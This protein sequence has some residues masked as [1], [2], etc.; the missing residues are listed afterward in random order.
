MRSSTRVT[1]QSKFLELRYGDL[2][3]LRDSRQ[4]RF[5]RLFRR[6]GN[7]FEEVTSVRIAGAS[8]RAIWV[9]NELR[10]NMQISD[11]SEEVRHGSEFLVRRDLF[12]VCL[13]QTLVIVLIL[14]IRAVQ[15]L[16]PAVDHDLALYNGP[17]QVVLI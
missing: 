16:S 9:A 13:S 12:Q 17:S 2:Q 6:T 7:L 10:N 5:E 11:R 8:D 1:I 3:R 14:C 4:P 15:H